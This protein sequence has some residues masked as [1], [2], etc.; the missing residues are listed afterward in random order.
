MK[1]NVPNR[2]KWL[3]IVAG[4]A[5]GLYVLDSVVFTPLTKMWQAHT[6][7]IARLQKSVASGRATIA[8][9]AQ[10]DRVWAE[11]QANALP[12]EP[13]QAEQDVI[14]AFDRWGRANNIELSSIRPQWKRGATDRYSLLECRVDAT[15]SI[16]TL[17]RFIYELERSPLA[18]RVDSVELTARDDGGSRLTLGLIVSGLRLSPLERK[19]Q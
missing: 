6:A 13:A 14:S 12:K 15:G 9:A 4:T 8:R 18:L 11:M 3:I 16:P 1:L 17:S 7:E 10:I 19:Q 5:V 2:Q